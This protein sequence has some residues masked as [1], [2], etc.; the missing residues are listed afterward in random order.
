MFCKLAAPLAISLIDGGST[1]ASISTALGLTLLSVSVEYFCIARVY[2]SA[3]A[4]HRHGN[5]A[6]GGDQTDV[7][8]TMGRPWSRTVWMALQKLMPLNALPAYV[9]HR[10]FLPSFSLALLY[11]T[12]LSFSGQ[13]IT[14]LKASGYS[15]IAVGIARTLATVLE[16]SA[17]WIGPFLMRRI[18]APRAGLWSIY[19]QMT[20]LAA[21]VAWYFSYAVDRGSDKSTIF[22]VTG[23]AVGV[24]LSR[25]GLWGFDL[26]AQF[27]IQEV[28]LDIQYLSVGPLLTRSRKCS[29]TPAEHSPRLKHRSRTC[30]S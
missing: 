25:I 16:L 7:R 3:P 4:L 9:K 18:G 11:L 30:S 8:S 27:I 12:V 13:M 26:A 15:S 21:A 2:R 22:A 24:G 5:E 17:T 29:Q 23:L 6:T 10:A 14:F 19:W 1:L 28:R 20:C